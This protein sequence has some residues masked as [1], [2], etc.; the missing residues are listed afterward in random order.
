MVKKLSVLLFL[1]I[2]F[3]VLILTNTKFF[4]YI[5]FFGRDIVGYTLNKVQEI[6]F[7]TDFDDNIAAEQEKF[8]VL[9]ND[10]TLKI[11]TFEKKLFGSVRAQILILKKTNRIILNL[12]DNLKVSEVRTS[13]GSKKYSHQNNKIEINFEEYLVPEDV[14]EIEIKYH[15][16]P[17]K[18]GLAGF[19]FVE[20]TNRFYTLSQPNFAH[21]WWPCKDVPSD[22]FFAS[23]EII[24]P[25]K[26]IAISNGK[27]LNVEPI[28]KNWVSYR[29]E[30]GYPI[31][32]YLISVCGADYEEFGETFTSISGKTIPLKYFVFEDKVKAAKKDFEVIPQIM[33]AF[34]KLI[35]EYPFQN[36]HYGIVEFDWE[37]GG[38][39]HQTMTS[40]SSNYI[41]GLRIHDRLLAHELAHEWFGNSATLSDWIDIWLN[42]GFATYLSYLF[43]ELD[44][45]KIKL[46]PN[47]LFYG[48]LFKPNGF[49]FGNTIYEKGAWVIHM[50][51]RKVGDENFFKSL[52]KYYETGKFGNVT[53]GSLKAIFESTCKGDFSKFFHQWIYSRVEKPVFKVSY[54]TFKDKN[55][56]ICTVIL[57]QIQPREIFENDILIRLELNDK[58]IFETSVLNNSILQILRFIVAAPVE[59]L[60]IDPSGDLLKKVIYKNN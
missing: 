23:V 28:D 49:I 47:Q 57:E 59:N 12:Y 7:L 11:V 22:K 30:V 1:N 21:S 41:T 8:D 51:R 45:K 13:K 60:I 18:I 9:R 5:P 39:E 35:G 29:Y 40:I 56:Y 36:E 2:F 34:E 24:V 10:L 53:T 33:S 46:N 31:A 52:Q 19:D 54:T 38:M 17:R 32:S 27:L 44:G 4:S 6:I 55:N 50:L 37:F 43:F 14:V 25:D 26:L 42:E 48:S 58:N 20:G 3:A 15:G 16:Y